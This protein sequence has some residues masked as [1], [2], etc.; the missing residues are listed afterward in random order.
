MINMSYEPYFSEAHIQMR[1][2]IRD[3]VEKEIKPNVDKWE[4]EGLFSSELFK[5]MADVGLLGLQYPEEVGGQG[6]DYF[7]GIVLAEELARSGCGSIPMAI[8]V[9]TDMATPPIF[10]FGTKEQHE[11]YL[12]PALRGEK[13]ASIGITEPNHGSDVQSIETRAKRVD[14]GWII[15]GRK[16]FITNGTRADFVTLVART[17]DEKGAKGIS[18]FIV[19][20]DL[21]GFSVSKPFEK[22]GMR[23][24]DTAELIFDNVK[25]PH[26]NLLG[27]EG[28]GFYQIMWQ[29]QG[30]RLNGAASSIGMAQYAYELALDYAQTRY[31]FEQPISNFQVISHLLAEMKTEIEVCRELTYAV[32]YKFSQGE[33]LPKEISMAKL[34]AVQ[35]SHW[36]VDR[37]LQIFGGNGY[38]Q[39]NPIERLWRDSR[40]PRIGGGTDE[41]MKE[42]IAGQ[43]GL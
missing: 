27:E 10:K 8:G 16:T 17:S 2:I 41:I 4:E 30:E 22:V 14:D 11:K 29:L 1:K 42:I 32:A 39:E 24:S 26:E 37:A 9:Q 25:V 5:R 23:S 15:N 38:M 19:D 20:T 36:V 21:P 33:V 12:K 28:K 7:M 3:F 18:L 6:G 34:S 31:S 35:M 13:I 40:L 43:M